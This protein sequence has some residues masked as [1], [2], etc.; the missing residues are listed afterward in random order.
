MTIVTIC[1]T[2]DTITSNLIEIGLGVIFWLIVS[3]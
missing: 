1:Y 2:P 3:E